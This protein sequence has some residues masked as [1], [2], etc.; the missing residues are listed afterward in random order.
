MGSRHSA[1]YYYDMIAGKIVK[2]PRIKGMSLTTQFF[3]ENV[4]LFGSWIFMLFWTMQ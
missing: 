4:Y 2:V 1:F 3:C